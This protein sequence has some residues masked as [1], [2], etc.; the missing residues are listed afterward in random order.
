MTLRS[1]GYCKHD[2]THHR[3]YHVWY[4]MLYRCNNPKHKFYGRYGG[5]GITV[6]DRWLEIANFI[7][8]MNE[9][10]VEGMLL[11]RIDNN[12]NYTPANCN[13]VTAECQQNNKSNNINI[14]IDGEVKTLSRWLKQT[15]IKKPTYQKRIKRGMSRIE[16]I[17][18]PIDLRF[19][20]SKP[21]AIVGGSP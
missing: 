17:T 10:Y 3:L 5:R 20:R 1:D 13:W 12:G 15:G 16:A 11:N 19:S 6:C 4:S 2:Y 21:S 14:E 18:K 7:E 9:A 8:D